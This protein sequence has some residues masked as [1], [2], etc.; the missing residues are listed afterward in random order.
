ML[1]ASVLVTADNRW[2]AARGSNLRLVTSFPK[3]VLRAELETVVNFLFLVPKIWLFLI[4]DLVHSD[5]IL[6]AL[7]RSLGLRL[8]T[9]LGLL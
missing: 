7:M 5:G 9:E 3:V 1:T 8:E 4:R 6:R 2:G